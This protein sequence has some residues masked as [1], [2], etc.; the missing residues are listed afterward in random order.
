MKENTGYLALKQRQLLLEAQSMWEPFIIQINILALNDHNAGAG[1]RGLNYALN[2]KR[3]F[4][5]FR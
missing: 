5:L 4:A 3:S 1:D 2:Y